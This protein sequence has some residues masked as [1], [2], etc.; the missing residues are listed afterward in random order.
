MCQILD[1]EHINKKG[2]QKLTSSI[3]S[4]LCLSQASESPAWTRTP[5][6]LGKDRAVG[7]IYLECWKINKD[8]PV[9]PPRSHQ[10]VI[11]DI[12]TVGGSQHYDMISGSHSCRKTRKTEGEGFHHHILLCRAGRRERLTQLCVSRSQRVFTASP[13]AADAEQVSS[14]AGST[15]QQRAF[16]VSQ[17]SLCSS[18]ILQNSLFIYVTSLCLTLFFLPCLLPHLEIAEPETRTE[19]PCYDQLGDAFSPPGS[20]QFLLL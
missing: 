18:W 2:K 12:G 3:C 19:S 11:Q 6:S 7:G 16:Q 5:W 4:K 13:G 20:S 8:V 1:L 15:R 14:A 17:A 10:G 9:K